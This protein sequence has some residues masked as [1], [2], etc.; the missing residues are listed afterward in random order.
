MATFLIGEALALPAIRREMFVM[1]GLAWVLVTAFI[2]L[3][4]EPTLR[5]LFGEDYAEY[6]RSVRRWIPRLTPFEP[7]RRPAHGGE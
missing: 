3:Y 2:L 7:S 4:E 5:R 1:I 6:C